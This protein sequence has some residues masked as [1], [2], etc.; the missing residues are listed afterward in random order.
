MSRYDRRPLREW[1]RDEDRG[2]MTQQIGFLRLL[3]FVAILAATFLVFRQHDN[4]PAPAPTSGTP[5][6]VAIDEALAPTLRAQLPKAKLTTSDS[7]DLEAQIRSGL[8]VDLAVLGTR[9]IAALGASDRCSSPQAIASRG[10]AKYAAC[11]VNV[12][13]ASR[14]LAAEAL[15]ALTG[16]EGRDAL[17]NAGYDIPSARPQSTSTTP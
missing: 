7:D 11:L 5:P 4:T 3:G 17:L 15:A 14:A 9:Q 8:T 13:G 12:D 16:L 10:G 2:S 6:R 1:E